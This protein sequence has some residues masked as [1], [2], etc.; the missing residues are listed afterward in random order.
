MSA[1]QLE[2]QK[3]GQPRTQVTMG[4]NQVVELQDEYSSN[5]QSK[6]FYNVGPDLLMAEANEC[7]RVW[8]VAFCTDP[9]LPQ[10][11]IGGELAKVVLDPHIPRNLV[12]SIHKADQGQVL[13]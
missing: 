6:I 11:A 13:Q 4:N 10:P 7:R 1:D 12:H 8:V 5:I 9:P 3:L 2:A